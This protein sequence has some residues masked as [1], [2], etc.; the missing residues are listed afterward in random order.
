MYAL[1]KLPRKF[2]IKWTLNNPNLSHYAPKIDED[3]LSF[4]NL[5][6]PGELVLA[7]SGKEESSQ[8]PKF[9]KKKVVSMK[10]EIN[11]KYNKNEITKRYI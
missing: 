6:W 1:Q 8:I 10:N 7:S 3:F 2:D 11:R 9:I 4:W 5:F